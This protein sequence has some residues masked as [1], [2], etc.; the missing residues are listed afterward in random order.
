MVA[1][2]RHRAVQ[3]LDGADAGGQQVDAQRPPRPRVQVQKS[4]HRHGAQDH[5][6]RHHDPLRDRAAARQRPGQ[7]RQDQQPQQPR[8]AVQHHADH[9]GGAG[10]GGAV[11]WAARSS[12]YGAGRAVGLDHVAAVAAQRHAKIKEQP[13]QRQPQ[14]RGVADGQRPAPHQ[15]PPAQRLERHDRQRQHQAR[16]QPAPAGLG[17]QRQQPLVDRRVGRAGRHGG[18]VVPAH[19]PQDVTQPRADQQ[20]AR[21]KQEV[22]S[23]AWRHEG[24]S[25]WGRKGNRSRATGGARGAVHGSDGPVATR[26]RALSARRRPGSDVSGVASAH[27]PT[28][29]VLSPVTPRVAPRVSTTSGAFATTSSQS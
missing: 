18:V 14:R 9:R 5:P 1:V 13:H 17:H 28:T 2:A 25:R 19:R 27:A 21:G 7:G 6:R 23:E 15:P 20:Q 10:A 4:P 8:D 12:A 29:F 3:A 26:R 11:V 24:P 22:G 16:G